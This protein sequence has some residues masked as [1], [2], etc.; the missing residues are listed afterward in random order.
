MG[1]SEYIHN[2]KIYTNSRRSKQIGAILATIWL[3]VSL[4]IV[5][6]LVTGPAALQNIPPRHA[7]AVLSPKSDTVSSE[8]TNTLSTRQ[9][10]ALKTP[11]L[12][13]PNEGQF[14]N[15]QLRYVVSG[16]DYQIGV[17]ADGIA[18]QLGQDQPARLDMRFAGQ[19]ASP[20]LEGRDPGITRYSYFLGSDASQWR[21]GLPGYQKVYFEQLYPGIDAVLYGQEGRLEYDFILQPGAQPETIRLQLAGVDQIRLDAD[22]NL[23][24]QVGNQSIMQ[25]RPISHQIIDGQKVPVESRFVIDPQTMQVGFA[26]EAYNPVYPLIID[27]QVMYSAYLGGS[28]N[29]FA[30][31]V[32]ID[33]NSHAFITGETNSLDFL[34]AGKTKKTPKTDSDIFVIEMDE[35][36]QI[37]HRA[38]FGGDNIDEATGIAV[39]ANGL[40][41]VTGWTNSF[42]TIDQNGNVIINGF[43]TQN[44]VKTALQA[45]TTVPDI[46]VLRLR[47]NAVGAFDIDFGTYYGGSNE[48]RGTDIAVDSQGRMVVSFVTASSDFPGMQTSTTSPTGAYQGSFTGQAGGNPQQDAGFFVLK[49]TTDNTQTPPVTTTQEVYATYLGG[50]GRDLSHAIAIGPN[51]TIH[52]AGTTASTDFTTTPN[53]LYSSNQSNDRCTNNPPNGVRGSQGNIVSG[54]EDGFLAKFDL[55]QL[56]TNTAGSNTHNEAIYVTY[57]GGNSSDDILGMDV[58]AN[59]KVYLTGATFSSKETFLLD[60]NSACPGTL[61]FPNNWEPYYVQLDA[62]PNGTLGVLTSQIFTGGGGTDIGWD[63]GVD[64]QGIVSILGE[65]QNG[66]NANFQTTN[67]LAGH[68]TALGKEDVFLAQFDTNHNLIHSSLFGGADKDS[69]LNFPLNGINGGFGLAVDHN[70]GVMYMVGS[71]RSTD[72]SHT[73]TGSGTPANPIAAESAADP[74]N[75]N[76]SISH[77]NGFVIAIGP[78]VDLSITKALVANQPTTITQGDI[79]SFD[80]TVTNNSATDTATRIKVTDD[81]AVDINGVRTP[82]F[83]YVSFTPSATGLA[84]TGCSVD[85]NQ[86]LTCT[87]PDLPPNQ[88]ITFTLNLQA[89]RAAS[90]ITNIARV[91]ALGNPNG[92]ASQPAPAGG[93]IVNPGADLVM[94]VT[95]QSGGTVAQNTPITYTLTITNNGPSTAKGIKVVDT[96]PSNAATTFDSAVFQIPAQGTCFINSTRVSGGCEQNTQGQVEFGLN[97]INPGDSVK[98]DVTV[99]P[100]ITTGS[101]TNIAEIVRVTL[102]GIPGTPESRP[103]DERVTTVLNLAPAVDLQ[104]ALVGTPSDGVPGHPINYNFTVKN[105][106]PRDVNGAVVNMPIPTGVVANDPTQPISWSCALPAGSIG[107]SSCV[108]ATSGSGGIANKLV[109]LAANGGTLNFSL[110]NALIDPAAT[111]TI[112]ATI[113]VDAPSTVA[114]TNPANNTLVVKDALT[115]VTNLTLSQTDRFDP[116]LTSTTG[117][118]SLITYDMTVTNN[119]PSLATNVVVTDNLPANTTFVSMTPGCDTAVVTPCTITIPALNPG[120]SKNYTL[121]VKAPTTVP[122]ATGSLV[123]TNSVKAVSIQNQSGTGFIDE[124]TQILDANGPKSADLNVTLTATDA[125]GDGVFSAGEAVTYNMVVGNAGPFDANQASIVMN[126]PNASTF[127]NTSGLACTVIS[128]NEI[129]CDLGTLVQGTSIPVAGTY[130][131]PG[132]TGNLVVVAT[133]KSAVTGDPD[134]NNNVSTLNIPVTAPVNGQGSTNGG[135]GLGLP[136]LLLLSLAVGLRL[137]ARWLFRR[138]LFAMML[139]LSG[140]MAWSVEPLEEAGKWYVQIDYGQSDVSSVTAEKIIQQVQADGFGITGLKLDNARTGK[141]FVLGYQ[142]R[143]RW[144]LELGYVNLDNVRVRPEGNIALADVDAFLNSVL[145]HT[146]SKSRGALLNVNGRWP[147]LDAV[148]VIGKA[149]LFVWSS[150]LDASASVGSTVVR[151]VHHTD[152]GTDAFFGTGA[153]FRLTPSWSLTLE[154]KGFFGDETTTFMSGG[155]RYNLP[156]I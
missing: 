123:V 121:V 89:V 136:V 61:T 41:Y 9:T 37:L 1:F 105:I 145:M 99:T 90:G 56:S 42:E 103:G 33:A 117:N 29:D 154:W 101:V 149:G 122:A 26:V 140:G 108:G 66:V 57:L 4:L 151:T 65:T 84:P 48:D 55:S 85:A 152:H 86:L 45:A 116:V 68:A 38:Q 129:S 32:A 133:V 134:L 95:P 27:P 144:A 3:S 8:S 14:R 93:L 88:A 22:G 23:V 67:P 104:L 124:T 62:A 60:P 120:E 63:I 143:P 107:T 52:V 20:R 106:G 5:A 46:F 75:P 156:F 83:S 18:M 146:P 125:N 112:I 30:H 51:D 138:F 7:S 6:N 44:P 92:V 50:S 147:L 142:I 148:H 100:K 40:V 70:N 131:L 127:S 34:T 76:N 126:F 98:I 11:L 17:K 39:D 130:N 97:K 128:Q 13:V 153:Q 24:M 71:T 109:N 47:P 12:F 91:L 81:L 94:Q 132:T 35:T 21:S 10:H 139:M 43:P 73:L 118:D 155:F 82:N 36:G 58:D 102:N 16:A 59:G 135:G 25:S 119:G 77:Q 49:T 2:K 110:K 115:P 137:R 69:A 78:T 80:I 114:D 87:L 74:N 54:G 111:G 19:V 96:L 28:G 79:V 72:F 15:E 53:A 150:D 64:S 141:E 31:D 113:T